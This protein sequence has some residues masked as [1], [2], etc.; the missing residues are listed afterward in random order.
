[1]K[2]WYEILQLKSDAI[3]WIVNFSDSFFIYDQNSDER[4]I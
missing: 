1:M 3:H 4:L 2:P